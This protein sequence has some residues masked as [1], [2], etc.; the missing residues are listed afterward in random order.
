MQGLWNFATQMKQLNILVLGLDGA[1]KT[2]TKY[3]Y[4]LI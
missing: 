2:V 3:I 4:F 1:G